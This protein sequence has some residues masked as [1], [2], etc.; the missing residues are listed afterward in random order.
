MKITEAEENTLKNAK[1]AIYAIETFESER[2]RSS[3]W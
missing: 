2:P 3:N 1:N